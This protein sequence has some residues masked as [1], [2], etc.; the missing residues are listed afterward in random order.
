MM[1]KYLEI[2]IIIIFIFSFPFDVLGED[3]LP[4]Y[5]EWTTEEK[6]DETKVEAIQYGRQVPL[7]WSSWRV[8]KPDKTDVKSMEG[9]VKYHAYDGK[10][11]KWDNADAKT[12]YTWDFTA[13]SRITY[14][15]ADVDTYHGADYTKYEGPPLQLYCD[16]TMIASTGRHDY[17]KNWNPDIDVSCRYL[18]LRMST[19]NGDG[20]DKTSIVGTW[21]TRYT[22]LYAYVTK[23]SDGTDWRF[24][25]PYERIYGGE[26]PQIPCERTVYSYL[27]TY[28]I[29]YDLAG[30]E[31]LSDATYSYTV[32]DEV[33]IPD[34]YKMGYDFLGFYDD[35]GNK[36]TKIEK[37]SYG[38][39]NLT[40]KYERKMPS[41][42]V[43]YTYFLKEDK[44]ITD[45]ELLKLVNAKAVDELEGDISSNIDINY[46]DYE[47]RNI[48]TYFPSYLDISKEGSILINFY[49]KNSDGVMATIERRY[50][51]L[52]MGE[53][54]ENYSDNIKI[55]TR[56]IS[57]EY[58]DT[59]D[60]NSIW[61]ETDY[62]EI[63]NKAFTKVRKE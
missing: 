4:G 50:Y 42:Y 24:D 33:V 55:Y 36:V 49:V 3:T 7:K 37:G 31:F 32:F 9:G 13:S 58:I 61:K 29:N 43:G 27:L 23:W 19:N 59:L 8:K 54:I 57:E 30:G 34:A 63:L 44:K 62:Q 10:N 25:E 12:L 39:L 45:E 60:P 40:A 56:Y 47:S 18:E 38:D 51:I 26:N 53:N 17:L 21:A 14:F 1:K 22:T 2:I 6:D 35:N 46:I 11:M 41:I 16:G 20:R 15:Y 28:Q 52:G 5:S 48:I